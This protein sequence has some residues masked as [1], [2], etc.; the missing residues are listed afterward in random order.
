MPAFA[1]MTALL[2]VQRFL[3]TGGDM[4]DKVLDNEALDI[5]FRAARSH[6][7]WLDREVSDAQLRQLYDLMKWG[8]TSANC[9][10][11]R[12]VFVRSRPSQDHLPPRRRPPPGRAGAGRGRAGGEK[13]PGPPPL[14]NRSLQ[15]AYF[16]LAARAL[17]LDC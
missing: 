4:S 14:G 8:P 13:K 15:G 11:A 9:S 16:I 6:S 12:I 7:F 10:P 5:L 2:L 3:S 1:G 17:G